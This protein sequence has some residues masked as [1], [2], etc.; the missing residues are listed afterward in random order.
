LPD[1]NF[2]S[3]WCNPSVKPDVVLNEGSDFS[4]V[5]LAIPL[6]AFKR[7]GRDLGPCDELVRASP[8]FRAMTENIGLVPSLSVQ[9]WSGKSLTELGWTEPAPAMVS[10]PP[11][12]QIWADMSQILECEPVTKDG[13]KSLHYFCNVFGSHAYRD[14]KSVDAARDAVRALTIDWFEKTAGEFWPK[15]KG[16]AA[17]GHAEFDWNALHDSRDRNGVGRLEAQVVKANVDPLACC[18]GSAAGSTGWRLKT[19]ASGFRHLFL[20][21]SWID[22][23]FNTECIEAAVMSGKQAS[24]AICGSPAVV[25]GEHFMRPGKSAKLARAALAVLSS[26]QS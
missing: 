14:P 25:V 8:R 1:G 18:C 3:R 10:G 5:I 9:A 15:A 7:L 13:P 23:G 17:N 21:G 20:A 6:G 26:R 2:E 12:L 4:D 16:A 24:R 11:A 22:T 19:D